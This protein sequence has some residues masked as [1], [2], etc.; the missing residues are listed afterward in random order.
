[1]T[2]TLADS[3]PLLLD[4]LAPAFVKSSARARAIEK[5]RALLPIVC[6]GFE[7]RL[8]DDAAIDVF[9]CLNRLPQDFAR[10]ETHVQW[11]Q[12]TMTLDEKSD[13]AWRALETFLRHR[14]ESSITYET[15]MDEIW[16]ECDANGASAA[17]CVFLSF[18]R[19]M[20]KPT[21]I[22]FCAQTLPLL[23]D[24]ANVRV[25]IESVRQ[26]QSACP[27]GARIS[28]I[29]VMLGRDENVLRVNVK[30][31]NAQ[32]VVPFLERIEWSGEIIEL[33]TLW[34]QVHAHVDSITLCLDVSE[35]VLPRVG[36]ECILTKPPSREPRWNEWLAWLVEEKLCT[37]EKRE[38]LREW[39]VTITPAS[40]GNW[41]MPLVIQALLAPANEFAVIELD[42]SHIKLVYSPDRPLQAKAYLWFAQRMLHSD[43]SF[44]TASFAMDA[45][46]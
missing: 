41:S 38:A 5:A 7:V 32:T 22:E 33:K 31:L 1:M 18:R 9:Q 27:E 35:Q 19:E 6:G 43:I 44:N 16:L 17:P 2:A 23:I 40:H 4:A 30:G 3:L 20:E 12:R 28:H 13:S 8:Y 10:L 21:S 36:L 46:L 26:I 39:D 45:L 11:L 25:L 14:S 15:A 34:E 24:S 37:T 42:P 29:G